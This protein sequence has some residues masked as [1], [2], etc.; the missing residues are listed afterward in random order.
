M[1]KT[2]TVVKWVVSL[3]KEPQ[4]FLG[5]R[6]IQALLKR[7]PESKKYLWALR[8]LSLSPHYFID[9]D[10][11]AY[12]L[13][14]FDEYLQANF[15]AITKS[16]EGIYEKIL[17][18]HLKEGLDVLDYGCGPG[19]LAK[20]TAPHVKKIYAVDI[21]AG[22]ITC[23]TILNSSENV[24]YIVSDQNGIDMIP[25]GQ[26]DAVYSFAVVQH[27]TNDAF[28]ILLENCRRKLKPGGQLLLHIQ[29]TDSVWQT[30]EEVKTDK[31]LKGKVKYQYGLHCFGRSEQEHID[32][33]SKHQF[34]EIRIEKLEDF[35]QEYADLVHSQRLL[36]AR[37][38]G[39]NS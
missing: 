4:N 27:L 36:T 11:P 20:A 18:P 10:N 2:L 22:A 29:R 6:W 25:D 3:G 24:E 34:D 8:I 37:K 13:M 21:S 30:E 35:V 38:R 16:R 19:F 26:I 7:V 12:R 32:I 15:E 23:A 31:S 17:K 1:Q 5:E 39:L 14:S 33:V 28:E 9:S